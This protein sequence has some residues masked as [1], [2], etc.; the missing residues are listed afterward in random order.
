MIFL[1]TTYLLAVANPRDG[2]FERAQ[3]WAR[4]ITER[5]LVTEYVLC[6]V[7]NAYSMPADRAKAH[8]I[9]ASVRFG[10]DCEYV[11]AGSELFEAGLQLHAVRPD[12]EW[13]LTDCI[14][15]VV[16]E[17]RAITQALT[18]D[19]HFEQAGLDALLRRDPT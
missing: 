4:K 11:S 19:H 14:S 13:S 9:V 3:A 16:M 6:E 10:S 15:F 12:K 1:D 8:E 18:Y 7:V 17:Q 2:L 5:L